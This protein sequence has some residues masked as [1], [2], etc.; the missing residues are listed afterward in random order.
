MTESVDASLSDAIA[1]LLQA[2]WIGVLIGTGNVAQ[3]ASPT[4][5]RIVGLPETGTESIDWVSMTPPEY[6]A[7]DD[8]A[9]RESVV[10]GASGWFRKQFLRAD[11]TRVTA[12][13]LV[14]ALERDPLRWLAFLR[15][16]VGHTGVALGEGV[17]KA[18]SLLRLAR[19]LAG[20]GSID[21]VFAVV[22]RL[23]APALGAKLANMALLDPESGMLH[24]H[25]D[26]N[27]DDTV[28]ERWVS[29][30][31]T[32]DTL[33]GDAV[34]QG[35]TLVCDDLDDFQSRYGSRDG[36]AERL[37]LGALAATPLR[38]DGGRVVG[39]LGA[40]WQGA[41][42]VDVELLTAAA[43]LVA[44]AVALAE[45]VDFERRMAVSFQR[46]LLPDTPALK[47]RHRVAVRYRAVDR[48]VG[49]DFYD[50][51]DRGDQ[52]WLITGDVAGHGLRAAR[53][54]G[55][56]RFFIRAIASMSVTATD[57]LSTV[58]RL[59]L[60]ERQ[61]EMVTCVVVLYDAGRGT[62][63]VASA[64]HP[65]PVVM[66]S[67]STEQLRVRALPPLGVQGWPVDSEDLVSTAPERLV[68][69]T[70][71]LVERR[72]ELVDRSY[73]R[74]VDTIRS[75]SDPTIDDLADR[76]TEA[77]LGTEED[78][79]AILCV[80]FAPADEPVGQL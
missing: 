3:F 47:T 63:A 59:I 64:G 70:D 4:A 53:T 71:G 79:A 7:A 42:D 21:E 25:H 1:A 23:L 52:V 55:K 57:L 68:A 5:R 6:R 62:I 72:D 30:P 49:G 41:G 40:A 69:F 31:P 9:M 26:P 19:R 33:M 46:M 22:D 12:D 43:G 24:I 11:G 29:L 20:T 66:S 58:N 78:D 44:N 15:P 32:P 48:G 39:V 16:D 14:I 54:M 67:G 61:D 73:A 35:I 34:H 27:A 74:L 28:R 65:P 60:Q 2:E 80:E 17:S 51:I 76:L 38:T 77:R 37:G 56:V 18:S 10:S 36:D 50:V 8:D 75:T 13:V 45:K